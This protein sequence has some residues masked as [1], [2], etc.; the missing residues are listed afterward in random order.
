MDQQH[1]STIFDEIANLLELRRDDPFRI[2]AYRRAAQALLSVD[3]SLQAAAQRG[4]LKDIPGVGKTLASEIGELLDTGRLRYHD[5]LKSAVP[6]GMPALLR[7]PSLTI[8]QVRTLWQQ[9]RIT[10]LKQLAQAYRTDRTPLDAATLAALGRDLAAWERHENRMLLGIARP[11]AEV[12]ASEP[13]QTP[14]RST[15]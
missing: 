1:V 14:I 10:S 15:D 9:H 5:H 12:L 3:E 11:R 7:L 2:R 6:E 8:R 13:R 4:A